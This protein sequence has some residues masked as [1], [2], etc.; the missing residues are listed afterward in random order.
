METAT[1]SPILKN[2]FHGMMAF[3]LDNLSHYFLFHIITTSRVSMNFQFCHISLNQ[4]SEFIPFG[5]YD[6]YEWTW[7]NK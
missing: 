4:N 7:I 6:D 1:G 3:A 5:T 2:R